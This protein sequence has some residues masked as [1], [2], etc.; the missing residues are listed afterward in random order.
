MNVKS[1]LLI[2]FFFDIWVYVCD[3]LLFLSSSGGLVKE[4]SLSR[5]LVHPGKKDHE[6]FQSIFQHIQ[7]AQ[8]RR[9]P[10]ELFAQHIVTIVHHIKGNSR[11]NWWLCNPSFAL[12]CLKV[13][14]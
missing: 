11:L 12:R 7:S 13:Q 6:E 14:S 3:S 10:S 2:F 5:D 9:S 4:R 1:H 8:L